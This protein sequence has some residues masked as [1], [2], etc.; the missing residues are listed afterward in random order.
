MKL[1]DKGAL[2]SV[3]DHQQQSLETQKDFNS[4]HVIQR[5]HKSRLLDL[6]AHQAAR[7][8]LEALKQSN[9]H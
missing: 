9:S 2:T 4:L 1:A 7:Q 3:P 6:A 8:R 5:P